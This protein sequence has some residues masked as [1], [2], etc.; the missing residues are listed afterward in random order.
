M[1]RHHAARVCANRR[2]GC[3]SGESPVRGTDICARCL[4]RAWSMPTDKEGGEAGP[5]LSAEERRW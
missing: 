2:S 4:E 5:V 1:G 3:R